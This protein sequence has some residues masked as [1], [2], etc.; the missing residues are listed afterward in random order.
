MD[1]VW[2]YDIEENLVYFK[3][4]VSGKTWGT[5][6]TF[7]SNTKENVKFNFSTFP[8]PTSTKINIQGVEGILKYR[9]INTLGQEV[10]SGD[11][12]NNQ[13]DCS[14]LKNGIYLL[15]LIDE[16]QNIGVKRIF[17]SR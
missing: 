2:N 1:G 8:N 11:L 4:F 7:I 3:K 16:N 12:I 5:P 17:I 6:Y 9:L 10:L 15:R 13:I 14:I